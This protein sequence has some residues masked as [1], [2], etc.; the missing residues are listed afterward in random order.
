MSAADLIRQAVVQLSEA[1]VPS[2][3]HDAKQLLLAAVSQSGEA[4]LSVEQL[5]VSGEA[6]TRF[7]GLLARRAKREPLQHILQSA[8][9]MHLDLKSD[10]RALIPRDDSAE[11]IA[12]ATRRLKARKQDP[13]VIADLGTGSGVLLAECLHFFKVASGIAVEASTE[14]MSLADENFSALGLIDRVSLFP[15]SW[16][17]W[18]EWPKC[19]LIVSNPPYIESA[20]IPT[21]A[22]EVRDYDPP[23]ALDGGTDGLDAYREI[24]SLGNTH[25]KPG[26]HL[27]LEIGYDQRESVSLLLRSSGFTDLEFQ[28]DISGHDRVIAATKNLAETPLANPKWHAT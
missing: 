2:A 15:G 16:T 9:I 14:A 6:L 25:M 1:G 13:I 11:V 21:L 26:A 23:T 19:D 27:V 4:A 5:T 22:P 24:I 28:Q 20:I 18:T 7:K 8:S 10:A 12:L 17:D 3:R